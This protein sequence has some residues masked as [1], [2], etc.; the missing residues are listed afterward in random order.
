MIEY[1]D[2]AKKQGIKLNFH[3]PIFSYVF[4][5]QNSLDSDKD[6]MNMF[7]RLAAKDVIQ[8][9]VGTVIKPS[10]IYKFVLNLIKS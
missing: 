8:I 9:W 2:E 10:K 1:E 3:F 5:K 4:L 7:E 6:L